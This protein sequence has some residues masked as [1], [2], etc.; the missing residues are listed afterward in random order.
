MSYV[1]WEECSIFHADAQNRNGSIFFH[2]QLHTH[3][4]DCK[5]L[6][7][8]FR[9]IAA[10][11]FVNSFI[12]VI[13]KKFSAAFC[14]YDQTHFLLLS[15]KLGIFFHFLVSVGNIYRGQTVLDIYLQGVCHGSD[16][17][18]NGN[19]DLKC[20][21]QRGAVFQQSGLTGSRSIVVSL[22]AEK[23][24]IT[25]GPKSRLIAKWDADYL[26][27]PANKQTSELL[28]LCSAVI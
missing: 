14:K 16:P 25:M 9:V 5:C 27:L 3:M 7:P 6:G 21:C 2:T 12:T 1:S 19:C 11:S 23:A 22:S 15:W 20:R 28:K 26:H 13:E 24:E 17:F 18:D 8:I 10:M 4:G